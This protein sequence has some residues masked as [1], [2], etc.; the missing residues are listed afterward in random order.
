MLALVFTCCFCLILRIVV[1]YL[2]PELLR[3]YY[4]YYRSEFRLNSLAFGVI[5]AVMC[6]TL[7]GASFHIDDYTPDCRHYRN[8]CSDTLIRD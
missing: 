4:F 8:F 3:S 2:N 5:L 7:L 1:A 6:E